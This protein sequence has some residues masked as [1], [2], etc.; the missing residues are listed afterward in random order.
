LIE[1]EEINLNIWE[2][3]KSQFQKHFP[4]IMKTPTIKEIQKVHPRTMVHPKTK[5]NQMTRVTEGITS[6]ADHC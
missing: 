6:F 3:V 1:E 5:T 2:N 4:T